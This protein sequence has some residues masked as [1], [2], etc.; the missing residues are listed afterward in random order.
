MGVFDKKT[1]KAQNFSYYN[2]WGLS[3]ESQIYKLQPTHGLAKIKEGDVLKLSYD[4]DSGV[5]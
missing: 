3:S 1:S 4:A 2:T 5:F